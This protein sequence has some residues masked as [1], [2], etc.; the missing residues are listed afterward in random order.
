MKPFRHQVEIKGSAS[1][2]FIRSCAVEYRRLGAIRTS[3]LASNDARC[4][5]HGGRRR[6]QQA[7]ACCWYLPCKVWN[8]LYSEPPVKSGDEA[9]SLRRLGF[10]GHQMG[11]GGGGG[12][13]SPFPFST[14]LPARLPKSRLQAT[15]VLYRPF[16]SHVAPVVTWR[17]KR[18]GA[19]WI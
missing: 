7:I 3:S 12:G 13:S 14:S 15:M 19:W 2:T 17:I 8:G 11:R 5:M 1:I 9:A 6:C 18:R 16:G 10:S 4:M